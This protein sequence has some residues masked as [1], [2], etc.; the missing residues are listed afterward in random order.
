M[1]ETSLVIGRVTTV[2]VAV[3]GGERVAGRAGPGGT[4]DLENSG[5][6]SQDGT[7]VS[8]KGLHVL[9]NED[10]VLLCLVPKGVKTVS[11]SEHQVL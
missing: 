2:V 8:S 7:H 9:G 10:S 3:A 6:V 5:L 1:K 4:A 11:E